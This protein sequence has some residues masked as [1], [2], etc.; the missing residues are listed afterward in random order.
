M[1]TAQLWGEFESISEDMKKKKKLNS[2]FCLKTKSIYD[3]LRKWLC[4]SWVGQGPAV[5][6]V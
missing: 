5:S 6:C 3:N 4:V 2:Q 1:N